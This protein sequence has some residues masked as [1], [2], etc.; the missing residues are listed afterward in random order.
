MHHNNIR[1]GF[2]DLSGKTFAPTHVRNDPLIFAGCAMKRPKAKP[3][4]SKYTNA[5]LATP[6]IEDTGKQGDLLIRDL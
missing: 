4:I 3:A 2:T 5:T 6:L 1:D